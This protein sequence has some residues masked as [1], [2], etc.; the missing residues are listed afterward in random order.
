MAALQD[1]SVYIVAHN[2]ERQYCKRLLVDA[3]RR[4]DALRIITGSEAAHSG[5]LRGIPLSTDIGIDHAFWELATSR[6]ADTVSEFLALRRE[7]AEA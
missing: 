2:D 3:G 4:H 6:E 7:R 5:K 1:G